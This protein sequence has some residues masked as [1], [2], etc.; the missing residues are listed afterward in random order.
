M[1]AWDPFDKVING[2]ELRTVY[3]KQKYKFGRHKRCN[4]IK[5]KLIGW[6]LEVSR[7]TVTTKD[8]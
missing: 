8:D 2:V 5:S 6:K 4:G 7:I 1:N 3:L